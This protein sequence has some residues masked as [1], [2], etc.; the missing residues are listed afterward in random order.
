MRRIPWHVEE[1]NLLMHH[2]D[3]PW[4]ESPKQLAMV[5]YVHRS[6]DEST[7]RSSD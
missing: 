5:M 1:L 2:M 7:Q 3:D 4:M 6:H